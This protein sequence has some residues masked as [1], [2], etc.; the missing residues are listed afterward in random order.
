M[1]EDFLRG[2]A[3]LVRRRVPLE[4]PVYPGY[5]DVDLIREEANLAYCGSALHGLKT[6]KEYDDQGHF[7][8]PAQRYTW[9]WKWPRYGLGRSE[10]GSHIRRTAEQLDERG[11]GEVL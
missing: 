7:Q 10:G 4:G 9:Y 2:L 1:H 6:L 5:V 8:K 11:K 3:K